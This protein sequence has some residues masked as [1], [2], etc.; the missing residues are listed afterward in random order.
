MTRGSKTKAET[1]PV[2]NDTKYG[3]T[4]QFAL[5]TPVVRGVMGLKII[6]AV[7]LSDA[8]ACGGNSEAFEV[9]LVFWMC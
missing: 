1:V 8:L 6:M 4:T 2:H 9:V 3:S 7:R 5:L